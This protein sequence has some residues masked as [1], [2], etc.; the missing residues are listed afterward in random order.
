MRVATRL[1]KSSGRGG[2]RLTQP[3]AAWHKR[4]KMEKQNTM[5]TLGAQGSD[6]IKN[7]I[8]WPVRLMASLV[9]ILV[10]VLT[11]FKAS[12]MQCKVEMLQV[13]INGFDQQLVPNQN[14]QPLR[15]TQRMKSKAKVSRE[16]SLGD[17]DGAAAGG[18][19]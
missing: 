2:V 11:Q 16:G 6:G 4:L 8:A 13:Q 9:L 15:P 19:M 7:I 1:E 5:L 18:S 14:R 17:R 3:E 12:M 10:L